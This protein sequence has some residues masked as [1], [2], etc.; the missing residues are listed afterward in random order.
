MRKLIASA[1]LTLA[2]VLASI[3]PALASTIGPTG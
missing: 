1:V 2:G 3:V